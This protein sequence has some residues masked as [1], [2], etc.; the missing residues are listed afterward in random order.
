MTATIVHE[1]IVR[2]AP[3]KD[4]VGVA[5][6]ADFLLAPTNVPLLNILFAN[7]RKSDVL[8]LV[9][10]G[11]N[12]NIKSKQGVSPLKFAM[13][14]GDVK[15]AKDLTS[16]K[17]VFNPYDKLN[18]LFFAVCSGKSIAVDYV[19]GASSYE[20]LSDKV[21]FMALY[22]NDFDFLKKNINKFRGDVGRLKLNILAEAVRKKTNLEI[23][24]EVLR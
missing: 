7:N 13:L 22:K 23:A 1:L 12:I 20:M 24:K 9:D 2:K 8:S 6:G 11:W 3:L 16:R 21:F 17:A 19:F 10:S 4:I 14:K 15:F 18:E 5:G